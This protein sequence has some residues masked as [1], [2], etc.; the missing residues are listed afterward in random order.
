MN[1]KIQYRMMGPCDYNCHFVLWGYTDP[2]PML[3]IITEVFIFLFAFFHKRKRVSFKR[4][5]LAL[6]S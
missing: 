6:F 1:D 5:L 4:R 2:T 3:A